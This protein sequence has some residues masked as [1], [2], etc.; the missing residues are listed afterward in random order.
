MKQIRQLHLYLGTLFAPAIFFFAF[1]GALQTFSLH[2]SDDD[3]PNYTPPSWIVTIASI[4]KDQTLPKPH[5]KHDHHPEQASSDAAPAQSA[6]AAALDEHEHEGQ[7]PLP[8]K[9]FVLL[10]AIGLMTTALL[11]VYMALQS[12]NH[13]RT[14]LIM[15]GAGI[16]IPIALLV[17]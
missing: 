6:P 17:L 12:R 1:S 10:L 14:T 7:S 2:E 16:L 15:L 13:R 4:H 8:L 5:K 3:D 11:G 9:C